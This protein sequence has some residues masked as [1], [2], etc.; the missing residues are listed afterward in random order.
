MCGADSARGLPDL[1]P[2]HPPDRR[3]DDHPLP[4]LLAEGLVVTRNSDDPP[5]FGTTLTQEFRIAPR[6][7]GLGVAEL[8]DLS[9]TS[10]RASFL[11]EPTK[12]QFLAEIIGS[13]SPW[14]P[15]GPLS[16]I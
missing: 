14:G 4:K 11:D 6:T 10:A 15:V 13:T 7:F 3:T 2:A 8:A 9:R 1:Q 12:Q 5:M 16:A